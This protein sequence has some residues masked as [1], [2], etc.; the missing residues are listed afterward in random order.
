MNRVST[1]VRLL[2]VAA[3]AAVLL[4]PASSQAAG[5]VKGQLVGPYTSVN[6]RCARV[7]GTNVTA[8]GVAVAGTH[9]YAPDASIGGLAE[10]EFCG[11]RSGA[12]F[13]FARWASPLP[14]S[15]VLTCQGQGRF[16]VVSSQIKVTVPHAS[17]TP[18]SG[19]AFEAP[20]SATLK[21]LING[22]GILLT[23]AGLITATL[24]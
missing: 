10:N 13:L 16:Q 18:S 20:L 14:V 12:A 1:R 3:I 17:C 5:T 9:V 11:A 8:Y 19:S 15:G 6:D 22:K 7:F 21:P 2:G 4:I 24:G 23:G